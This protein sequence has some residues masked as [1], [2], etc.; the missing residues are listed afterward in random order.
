MRH[1]ES[2]VALITALILLAVTS[3]LAVSI[4]Y[5]SAMSAR[6]S[7]ASFSMEQGLQIGMGAEALAAYAL[8]EDKRGKNATDHLGEGWATAYGPVEVEPGV[9]LEAQLYDEQARFN[10][11]SLVKQ[12]ESGRDVVDPEALRVFTRLLELLEIEPAWAQKVVDWIDPD[13]TPEPDGGED[14]LYLSQT[15]PHRAANRAMLSVSELQQLPGFGPERYRR[16]LPHVSALPPSAN[17]INACTATPY[18]LDALYALSTANPNDVEFTVMDPESFAKARG[19]SCFPGASVL[20][21]GENQI[22]QR[23]EDSSQ[24]FQL[25]T[26]V[27]IGAAEFALYSLMY[28]DGAGNTRPVMRSFG[29]E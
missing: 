10:L 8:R 6:R 20:A 24:Y 27:R 26:W 18:V 3:I 19:E 13:D 21:R 5:E 25:R 11:N 9:S 28:R 1:R 4:G 15:P 23:V 17:K 12:D 2:G 22:R 16:L 14:S 7:A 29:T